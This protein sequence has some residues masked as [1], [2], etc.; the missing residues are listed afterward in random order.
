M[1]LLHLQQILVLIWTLLTCHPMNR[2]CF[3]PNPK[4]F[5]FYL[6]QENMPSQLK[7]DKKFLL[8]L[9][10]KLAY[11]DLLLNYF[12]VGRCRCFPNPKLFHICLLQENATFQILRYH[13]IFYKKFLLH[14]QQKL[15]YLPVTLFH[16]Q[17]DHYH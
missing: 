7:F 2:H 16:F 11:I 10:Q 5:H 6:L 1:F 15:V 4:L 12:Q 3:G 17:L 13:V 9:Q 8:Y 14:L